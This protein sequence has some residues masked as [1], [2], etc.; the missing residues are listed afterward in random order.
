[1]ITRGGTLM[2]TREDT[3]MITAHYRELGLVFHY[4]INSLISQLLKNPNLFI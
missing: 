4:V 3:I 2:I 1:M